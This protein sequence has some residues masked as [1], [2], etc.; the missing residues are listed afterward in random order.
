MTKIRQ[1]WQDRD[2]RERLEDWLSD[3]WF[4]LTW[5]SKTGVWSPPTRRWEKNT[6]WPWKRPSWE[7]R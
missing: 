2:R 5:W 1:N 7:K 6:M 3:F 4:S